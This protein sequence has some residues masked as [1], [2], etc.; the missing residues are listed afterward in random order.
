MLNSPTLRTLELAGPLTRYL[1]EHTDD[2]AYRDVT[3]V[4]L[5]DAYAESVRGL[6]D[7][8]AHI[9][10]V[11]T[12]FDTLNGKAALYAIERVFEEKKARVPVMASVTVV[13]LS[14][15]NLSGQTPEAFYASVTH[16][17]LLSVGINCSLGSDQMRSYLA[18]LSS[19]S[20]HFISCHPNAG[21]PNEF[22]EYDQTPEEMAEIIEG[23]AKDGFL[24][25]IGGCCGSRPDHIEAIARAVAKYPPRQIPERPKALRLSG[26]EPFTG[27]ENTLFINVGERTNVTGSKRFLRLIKEEQYEEALSVARDQVENGAQ[28]I[29][30][31]MDEGMLDSREV[32]VTFLNLVAS[33]PDISR[34]P[35]MIDS[36]K[37]D[38][39]EAGLRCIQ[40][41]AVV[42]ET[43]W[44]PF[45]QGGRMEP[46]REKMPGG[47][48]KGL[49]SNQSSVVGLVVV[50]GCPCA[51]GSTR[52]RRSGTTDQ[53]VV[54][55]VDHVL[56]GIGV[57]ER[58]RPVRPDCLVVVHRGLVVAVVQ[59]G[60]SDH[61]V[62]PARIDPVDDQLDDDLHVVP[63]RLG[64]ERV[65]PGGLVG[66]R[67]NH[68]VL[69]RRIQAVQRSVFALD[70]IEHRHLAVTLFLVI[71]IFDHLAEVRTDR[72]E[73]RG[74]EELRSIEDYGHNAV[75][76]VTST[77]HRAGQG[78]RHEQGKSFVPCHLEVPCT[79]SASLWNAPPGR[80]EIRRF[81]VGDPISYQFSGLRNHHHLS[82]RGRK[83]RLQWPSSHS[84]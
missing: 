71:G 79:G 66:Q 74:H 55:H 54:V 32:M 83:L 50:N 18:G 76:D 64:Q 15:R 35:I 60:R 48:A 1:N 58:H 37:W 78:Q 81:P 29:D 68:L 44:N 52:C 56:G 67:P 14:G 26:L 59:L 70:R 25:I 31:N 49:A 8:G 47:K 53:V 10:M 7:G 57:G 82:V 46:R 12:V 6:L 77:A 24:N 9:L 11:E 62:E 2:P 69:R 41:K 13:D 22:G 80:G 34:V 5:E 73:R 39:I 40:G 61:R 43:P 21:L 23:F 4:E 20:S 84:S 38:V 30:I 75:E 16:A 72:D 36:S 63:G 19:V 27:D 45:G 42:K 65:A 51:A 28:I 33:E 17:P 3:F